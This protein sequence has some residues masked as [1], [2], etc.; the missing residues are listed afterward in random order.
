MILGRCRDTSL[1]RKI[2][3]KGGHLGFAKFV[4]VA[5]SVEQNVTLDPRQVCFLRANTVM[6]DPQFPRVPVQEFR[7]G[8]RG[9]AG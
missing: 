7:L 2:R 3:D 8:G 9:I 5:L 4:R 6:A 1:N